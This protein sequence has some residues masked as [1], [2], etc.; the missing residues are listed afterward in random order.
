MNNQTNLPHESWRRRWKQVLINLLNGIDLPEDCGG[1]EDAKIITS[2][3]NKIGSLLVLDA[4][5]GTGR[6]SVEL[7]KSG[8]KVVCLDIVPEAVEVSQ[9]VYRNAYLSNSFFVVGN[10]NKLPFKDS[11]FDLTYGGGVIEHFE[12]TNKVLKEY[13]RVAKPNGYVAVSVPNIFSCK[14]ALMGHFLSIRRF[15]QFIRNDK[16]DLEKLFTPNGFLRLLRENKLSDIKII[17]YRLDMGLP[18]FL[19]N[20]KTIKNLVTLLQSKF[21]Q[22]DLGFGF[23]MGIGKKNSN[24]QVQEV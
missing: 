12:D 10:I 2:Y 19:N 11:T 16:T 13:I 5:C 15:I 8:A 1:L 22:I 23:F 9:V 20:S 18:S 17:P 4:G 21:P 14:P 24:M 6:G 3:I 7:A